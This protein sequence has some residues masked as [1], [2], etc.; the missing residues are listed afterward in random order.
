[1]YILIYSYISREINFTVE[2]KEK[3]K[4]SDN[5]VVYVFPNQMELRW[6][7]LGKTYLHKKKFSVIFVDNKYQ[8]SII[9]TKS[10]YLLI[11]YIS[12]NINHFPFDI[13]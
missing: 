8:T 12:I 6:T 3:V 4:R 2:L 9:N 5:N 13:F 11:I 7:L 1:M 10:M